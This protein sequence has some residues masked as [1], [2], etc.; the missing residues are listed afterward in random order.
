[1]CGNDFHRLWLN[2]RLVWI[3]SKEA[4]WQLLNPQAL[5]FEYSSEISYQDRECRTGNREI[6]NI[7]WKNM[8]DNSCTEF[9]WQYICTEN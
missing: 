6:T 9:R 4:L 3:T 7:S 2:S 1:M 5:G 8:P